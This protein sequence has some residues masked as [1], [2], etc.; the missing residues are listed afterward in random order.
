[1]T[2]GNCRQCCDDL[3]P[4][5]VLAGLH[6]LH[7]L[8]IRPY[9]ADRGPHG[10]IIWFVPA[11]DLVLVAMQRAGTPAVA[12]SRAG[13]VSADRVCGGTDL[14]IRRH[15]TLSEAEAEIGGPGEYRTEWEASA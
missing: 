2:S 8:G 3:I 14:A 5:D 11:D 6:R 4:A 15:G 1:M 13:W 12:K 10:Q 7:L 9:R